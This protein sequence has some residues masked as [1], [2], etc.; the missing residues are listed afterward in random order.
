MH[1]IFFVLL[2]LIFLQGCASQTSSY[3]GSGITIASGGTTAKN[4]FATGA[5]LLIEN[6]ES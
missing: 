6:I 1:R 2:T 4:I 5:N 3:L